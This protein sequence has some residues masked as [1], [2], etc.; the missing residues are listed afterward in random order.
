MAKKVDIVAAELANMA[1]Q[2]SFAGA[3]V[4]LMEDADRFAHMDSPANPV[5]NAV[6]VL[7]VSYDKI[8]VSATA[9]LMEGFDEH[10]RCAYLVRMV[11]SRAGARLARLH[12]LM[13]GEKICAESV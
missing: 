3:R 5:K 1:R 2:E 7:M 6:A 13:A 8:V 10:A 9:V 11:S 12:A 4:A